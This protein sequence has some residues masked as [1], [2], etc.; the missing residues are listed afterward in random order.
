MKQR[1]LIAYFSWSGNTR[2]LA[3]EIQRK[4]GGDL[5]EIKAASPYPTAY[6]ACTK[7]AKMEQQADQ[8]P[9][10][11]KQL[12][13]VEDYDVLLLGYPNWWSSMPMPVW[14]F[15]EACDWTGKQVY[16]F[17]THGGGGFGH[18]REDLKRLLPG[19]KVES[20]FATSEMAL[21]R[22]DASLEQWLK[23]IGLLG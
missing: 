4:V 21:Q 15:L 22:M 14:T 17:C 8:R 10:L 5:F 7:Q 19:A 1:V 3:Q 13:S 20:G 9:A 12:T 18:S 2:K 6:S 11:Q 16:P 23:G